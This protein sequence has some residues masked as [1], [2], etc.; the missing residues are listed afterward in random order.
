MVAQLPEAEDG[1]CADDE[2]PGVVEKD[3]GQTGADTVAR[4]L[5][6]LHGMPFGE[7]R[8]GSRLNA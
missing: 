2:L 6:V 1:Q 5:H 8:E 7:V 4:H 3:G